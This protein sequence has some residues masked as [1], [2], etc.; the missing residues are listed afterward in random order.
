MSSKNLLVRTSAHVVATSVVV[1]LGLLIAPIAAGQGSDCQISGATTVECGT[2]AAYSST[3]PGAIG[4]FSIAFSLSA[5]TAGA[6]FVGPSSCPV[7]MP[8]GSCNVMVSVAQVGGFT[9]S[10]TITDHTGA[11]ISCGMPVVVNDTIPPVLTCTPLTVECGTQPPLVPPTS[12]DCGPVTYTHADAPGTPSCA[13]AGI[14]RTWTGTDAGGNTGTCTQVITFVDTTP[15]TLTCP[16]DVTVPCGS[17]TSPYNPVISYAT[18]QDG[19]CPDIDAWFTQTVTGSCP[20]GMVITRTWHGK[21]C[22]G[23]MNTCVQI[24]TVSGAPPCP[25]AAVTDRGGNC[26]NDGPKLYTSLPVSGP[27]LQVR[28]SSPIPNSDLLFAAQLPPFTTPEN[29]AF[30]CGIAHIEYGNPNTV[31]I[32]QQYT[33]GNGGWAQQFGFDLSFAPQLVGVPI[34]F[35]AGVVGQGP[36]GGLQL[37]NALEI[38]GGSC[39]LYCTHSR[40]DYAGSGPAATLLSGTWPSV[41][42]AGMTI[43]NYDLGSGP[44]APN[45]IQWT[46]DASG[47]AS[48]KAFLG[49]PSGAPSSLALDETNA[50]ASSAGSLG[51]FAAVLQLNIALSGNGVL[52]NAPF[53]SL[54]YLKPG[55]SLNGL[56]VSQILGAVNQALAGLG[57]PA[58]YSYLDLTILL[59]DLS[60]AFN[61]CTASPWA[62]AHLFE[63]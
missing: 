43:G 44:V 6:A 5:N 30:G 28:L 52:G 55:D 27:L 23:N 16:P 48:L 62:L 42:P 38:V 1:A 3:L 33:D 58:G 26:E 57:L 40:E 59:E 22:C 4:N 13:G 60:L 18:V 36:A 32:G 31:L 41:F 7:V 25:I 14:I 17:D 53:G 29:Y 63:N 45:G 39:V 51:R 19:C 34:L 8:G 46:G 50:L 61:A 2:T 21:D 54:V 12:V 35:Q 37:S 10:I 9:I 47:V 56:T 11:M 15:P 24:I 20:N 49:A